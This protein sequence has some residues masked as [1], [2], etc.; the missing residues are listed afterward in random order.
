M[1]TITSLENKVWTLAPFHILQQVKILHKGK[2]G[3]IEMLIR[4]FS[5]RTT[6]DYPTYLK[7]QLSTLTVWGHEDFKN[8][9]K[10]KTKLCVFKTLKR[11]LDQ[12]NKFW[13]FRPMNTYTE[14]FSTNELHLVIW[15]IRWVCEVMSSKNRYHQVK[16]ARWLPACIIPCSHSTMWWRWLLNFLELND[17]SWGSRK[18]IKSQ[19]CRG[20]KNRSENTT[21]SA[22]TQLHLMAPM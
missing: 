9:I 10:K 16:G 12:Q 13:S 11:R 2:N 3:R 6:G 19:G 4:C 21:Y 18:K 8:L 5:I 7:G 20:G 15:K 14:T 1:F 17:S 22:E